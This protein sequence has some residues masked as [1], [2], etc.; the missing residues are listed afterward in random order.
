M[1]ALLAKGLAR[2]DPLFLGLDVSLNGAL[3]GRDG[4]ISESLY[5]VG[6]ALKGSLWESTAVPELRE[7]IHKLVQHIMN[8][9]LQGPAASRESVDSPPSE[10]RS[11]SLLSRV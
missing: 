11:D 9:G 4:N 2:P 5:A 1:S 6:P 3:I 8:T 10:A 7:Q